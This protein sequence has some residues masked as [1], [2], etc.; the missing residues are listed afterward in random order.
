[1]PG[2]LRKERIRLLNQW[3]SGR[4]PTEGNFFHFCK[5]LWANI[6]NIV[7]FMLIVKNSIVWITDHFRH[8]PF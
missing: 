8:T 5:N 4:G 1:M 3:S 6:D 7:N 2:W